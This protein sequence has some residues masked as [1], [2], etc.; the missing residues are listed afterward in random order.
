M[1]IKTYV[2]MFALLISITNYNFTHAQ[3]GDT[4]TSRESSCIIFGNNLHYRSRDT[5]VNNEASRLQDYLI[6]EGYMSGQTTGYF[7]VVTLKAVKSFQ[8]KNGLISSGYVGALT[9][10]KI[11]KLSCGVSQA[12][13]PTPVV[14]PKPY[15]PIPVSPI[16]PANPPSDRV[17][18][19]E[20][21][22]CPDGN[23]YVPR[24]ANCVWHPEMCKGINV[25]VPLK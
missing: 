25:S 8:S 15:Q 24:D 11:K 9:R 10:A 5:S 17:C 16:N 23:G 2:L 21:K 19:M 1:K 14:T 6:S 3:V 12:P 20:V 13:N 22:R 7:G 4:D 18:T